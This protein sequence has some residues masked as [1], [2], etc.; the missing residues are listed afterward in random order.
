VVDEAR[1]AHRWL[2]A[3][4]PT[5][6]SDLNAALF[7]AAHSSLWFEPADWAR[8]LLAGAGE[9]LR[10]ELHGALVAVAGAAAHR[11]DLAAARADA[12]IVAAAASGRLRAIAL[13][14]LA[15]VALYEGDLNAVR[16]AAEELRRLGADLGDAHV[17]AFAAIDHSLARTYGGDPDTALADL[18]VDLGLLSPTDAAWLAYA[19]GEALSA[20]CD[21]GAAGQYREAIE[22]GSPVG[23]RFVISVAL[24]SLATDLTRCGDLGGALAVYGDALTAFRRHG[25]HTHA[26]TAM[27]NLVGLLADLG[28]DRGAVVLGA[29]TSHEGG[30][31]SYG[32]EATLIAGA[33]E[34]VRRRVGEADFARWSAEGRGLD[35]GQ[36]LQT[37]IGLVEGH[38][39]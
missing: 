17:A 33:L 34:A 36:S 3:S 13:E 28:D 20:A 32:A 1:S 14:V 22:L 15:D 8:A 35:V 19:R 2:Q 37:A 9:G 11:G 18:E 21:P 7:H 5:A 24:T 4:R 31:T 16:R 39:P 30:R 29:A 6:A 26:T 38:R 12:S 10:H 25:N 27:R 23:S